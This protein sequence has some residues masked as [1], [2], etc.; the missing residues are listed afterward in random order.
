M[1]P[2][3]QKFTPPDFTDE[4]LQ[5]APNVQVETVVKEGVAPSGFYLTTHMPTYY[6]V[7]GNWIIPEKSSLNCV[8]VLK[9][10][11]IEIT[12]LRDLKVGD[13]VVMTKNQDGST[14]I[15]RY[16][17]GFADRVRIPYGLSVETS[18][19]ASYEELFEL[20]KQEKENG[21]YIV[22]VLGPAVVFDHDTRIGLSRLAEAGYVQSLLGGNAM[23]THD[24][25]GGY[26]NTALGQ[27]IYTQISVPMGHYNHLDTLNA[28]RRVGSI[29]E[30]IDQ[31]NV[32]DGFIK[33][34]KS[35]D[36]PVTL[37]GSIRDD[38]PLPEVTAEVS[39]S[40]TNAKK[41]TDKATLIICLATML[42][43][44]STAEMASSYRLDEEGNVVPVYIFSVDVTENAV[45]KVSA[46]R[47]HIA[48]RTLVTNVQD[49][50]VNA[51]RALIPDILQES[52]RV[53]VEVGQTVA[54]SREETAQAEQ[55]LER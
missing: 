7:N 4:R 9:D 15:L 5:K 31:G 51:E 50:V 17:E 3:E 32:K 35:L 27:D 55:E 18:N 14:G 37:A 6:K 11:R 47:D 44:I 8:A 53:E 28:I 49:F 39:I 21:G 12:E 22:W 13:R 19:T 2:V 38:G 26:L 29:Q 43:S 20:M 54:I 23:A 10:D 48:V 46:A 36:V 34:L 52:N 40:L 24:L 42:H 16:A 45:N 1:A 41:E 33:T 30:F 25:E